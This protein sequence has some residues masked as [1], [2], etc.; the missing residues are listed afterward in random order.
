[1]AIARGANGP[2]GITGTTSSFANLIG[3]NIGLVAML[4]ANAGL[5]ATFAGNP[6]T[7]VES[8]AFAGATW[9]TFVQLNAPTGTNNFVTSGGGTPSGIANYFT[10]VDPVSGVDNFSHLFLSGGQTSIS[11]SITVNTNNSWVV[12]SINGNNPN[13]TGTNWIWQGA[14]GGYA[15]GDTDGAVST[16][17][18]T[19]KINAITTFTNPV[20]QQVS[21]APLVASATN[22]AFLMNFL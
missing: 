17:S 15:I 2:Y 10:G 9:Y 16:G 21:L 22:G 8:F 18:L 1:M 5:T 7:L 19:Q 20:I 12:A 6:M 14:N 11:N 13:H 4:V 3:S